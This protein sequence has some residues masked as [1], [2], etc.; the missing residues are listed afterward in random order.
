MESYFLEVLSHP[1]S[2]VGIVRT[3]TFPKHFL[4]ANS[5]LQ[6]LNILGTSD[7]IRESYDKLLSNCY[8]L[9]TVHTLQMNTFRS[10]GMRIGVVFCMAFVM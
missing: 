4:I 7:E 10:K 9:Y 6:D 8:C 3:L 5:R 2:T 1:E